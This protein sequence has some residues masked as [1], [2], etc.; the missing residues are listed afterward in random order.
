MPYLGEDTSRVVAGRTSSRKVVARHPDSKRPSFSVLQL[1][2]KQRLRILKGPW[3]QLT[4][5]DR[6]LKSF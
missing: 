6:L 1:P 4:E 3:M 5:G 2:I